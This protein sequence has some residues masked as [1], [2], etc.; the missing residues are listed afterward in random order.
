[1]LQKF[2]YIYKADLVKHCSS[3][4]ITVLNHNGA[5]VKIAMELTFENVS[6]PK[7]FTNKITAILMDV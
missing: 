3:T 2:I 5:D 6:F 1:M 7:E 4:Q